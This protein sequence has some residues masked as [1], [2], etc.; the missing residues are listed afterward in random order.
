MFV[1][2]LII[3]LITYITAKCESYT[4]IQLEPSSGRTL[5]CSIE[6]RIYR[7]HPNSMLGSGGQGF[8]LKGELLDADIQMDKGLTLVVIVC[9][10]FFVVLFF[11]F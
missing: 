4:R 5:T 2:D 9:L 10:F 6:D 3:Y 11:C 1:N 8:A 7:I